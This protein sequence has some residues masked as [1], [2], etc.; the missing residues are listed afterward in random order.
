MLSE[1]MNKVMN[2]WAVPT[3]EKNHFWRS[4][5]S[6]SSSWH[7]IYSTLINKFINP[8]DVNVNDKSK[9]LRSNLKPNSKFRTITTKLAK[10]NVCYG[11]LS[12]SVKNWKFLH[13]NV[14]F[15][16]GS[17]LHL[18]MCF[19]TITSTDPICVTFIQ[20]NSTI[21]VLPHSDSERQLLLPL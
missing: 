2:P 20:Y 18:L 19:Q 8:I 9:L 3:L 17:F 7:F 12:I 11:R 14:I 1:R 5:Q 4:Q 15:S 6:L 13:K 21:S 16:V 10:M